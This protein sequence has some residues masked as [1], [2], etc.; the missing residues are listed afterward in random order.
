MEK[1]EQNL[2]FKAGRADIMKSLSVA[3]EKPYKYFSD[4]VLARYEAER[5]FGFY[6]SWVDFTA[7]HC[8]HTG[9]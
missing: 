1:D 2:G 3:E 7:I 9:S 8:V 4:H 5:R 6:T